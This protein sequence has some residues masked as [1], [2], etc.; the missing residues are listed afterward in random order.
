MESNGFGSPVS[1]LFSRLRTS[2]LKMDIFPPLTLRHR[3]LSFRASGTARNIMLVAPF[4]LVTQGE[5][6]ADELPVFDLVDDRQGEV[7]VRQAHAAVGRDDGV[8]ETRAVVPRA[9]PWREIAR[10]RRD[11][12]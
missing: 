1:I 10:R 12:R 7:F 2:S 11:V 4:R 3:H 6:H 8:L 9:H 5:S